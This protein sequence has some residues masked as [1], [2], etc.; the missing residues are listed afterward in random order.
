LSGALRGVG[1]LSAFFVGVLVPV[2]GNWLLKNFDGN[3][4]WGGWVIAG[5]TPILSIWLLP[6]TG[7]A[8][9]GLMVV[10]AALLGGI[11]W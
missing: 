10:F 7:A 6:T 4:Y 9:I 1:P 3:M 2:G 8:R 11:I 5:V